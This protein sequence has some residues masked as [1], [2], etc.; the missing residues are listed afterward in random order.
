MLLLVD[1]F[2]MF[3][4]FGFA[5]YIR[6]DSWDFLLN[7]GKFFQTGLIVVSAR[8]IVFFF[9]PMYRSG[10]ELSSSKNLVKL[11]Q[12][13]LIS[14]LVSSVFLF[15]TNYFYTNNRMIPIID[16]LLLFSLL[17]ARNVGTKYLKNHLI[18]PIVPKRL[19]DIK[20]EDLL[21]RP[22]I[23]LEVESIERYIQNRVVLI[24]G[25]GGSIGS[26][27]SRQIYKFR[28]SKLILLDNG[29]TALYEI[30][31][32]LKHL[33]PNGVDI[34]PQIAD[35]KNLSRISQIFANHKPD[36]VFHC[37]A[38]KHV[39]IM[40]NH[41]SEAV[42]NNIQG[43]KNLVDISKISGVDKFVFISTDKAV[44]PVNIMGASKRIAELYVQYTSLSSKTKFITV[45][46]GNVLGSNGS[47]IPRFK[48]QIEKGGPITVTH[49]EIIRYFMT[50]PEAS[51]LVLQ[52]GSMGGRAEIFLLDM[53][54][55]VKILDLAEDMIRLSGLEPYKDIPIV[56]SGLRP[57]E[58]LYEELLLSV[59]GIKKTEH[60]KIMVAN[61]NINSKE[62]SEFMSKLNH[63]IEL[64]KSNK[65]EEIFQM[66]KNIVPE[67]KIHKDYI[68]QE[69]IS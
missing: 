60:S 56:F 25:A 51:Q 11:V 37:A 65:E 17:L 13:T 63:L 61:A 68:K 58:K 66:F 19:K 55:P 69:K 16:T 36:V 1:L 50:I 64:A 27:I 22:P 15:F 57:G 67:Y 10:F 42:L 44:N 59:E 6:F 45:R 52:A 14:S 24:T 4:S 9:S 48:E 29:E 31:Y 30:D 35:I 33:D 28:P 46:F 7:F 39:P 47:V 21:R 49:P 53:G 12:T 20:A 32:E 54:K 40:E 26:E 2:L 18:K 38:Y 34:I 8:G 62:Q 3:V 5:H 23:Q 41:P 43:T